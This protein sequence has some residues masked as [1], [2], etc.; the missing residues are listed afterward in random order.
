MPSLGG[1]VRKLLEMGVGTGGMSPV[2]LS[3]DG[4]QLAFIRANFSGGKDPLVVANEDGTQEKEV[5]T[6]KFPEQYSNRAVSWSPDGRLI[7]CANEDYTAENYVRLV[8]VDVSSGKEQPLS[9]HTW[10]SANNTVYPVWLSDGSGLIVA[11]AEHSGTTPQL[12]HVAYPGGEV[13]PPHP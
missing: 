10:N 2:S 6:R 11:A 13:P 1:G 9:P 12:W 8:G 4:R 7:A 5:V 3:P